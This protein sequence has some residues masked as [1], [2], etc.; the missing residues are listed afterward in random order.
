MKEVVLLL[1]V[2]DGSSFYRTICLLAVLQCNLNMHHFEGCLQSFTEPSVAKCL[3]DFSP[4]YLLTPSLQEKK[5]NN[6]KPE[7]VF[8]GS[9]NFILRMNFDPLSANPTK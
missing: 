9:F 7:I 8:T 5:V 4:S 3:R 1:E 6:Q 2:Y